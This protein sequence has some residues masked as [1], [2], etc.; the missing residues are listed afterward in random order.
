MAL[1]RKALKAMGCTDEQVDT[2]AEE[3][4][5]RVKSL[6]DEIE[7]LKAKVADYDD[8]VKERDELKKGE[9]WKSRYEKEHSDYE[10]YKKQVAEKDERTTKEAVAR[11]FF[12]EKGITGANLTIAMRGAK[13]E[14]DG[15]K[16]KDGKVDDT[17]ALEAL[18]SGDY[19]GLI[20]V[21][22]TQ[23]AKMPN[24]PT[25]AKKADYSSMSDEDYYKETYEKTKKKE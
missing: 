12:E 3:H 24:P 7:T 2:I 8:V 20:A 5:E 23:G 15:L 17:S 10:D 18:V 6:Q 4:G 21:T 25:G 19:A 13:G 16:L 9:D 22:E 14:I 11:A 1:T